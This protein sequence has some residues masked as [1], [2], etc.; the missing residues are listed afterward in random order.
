MKKNYY[1]IPNTNS[2]VFEKITI[3]KNNVSIKNFYFMFPYKFPILR[4]SKTF[5]LVLGI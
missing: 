4:F 1:Y 2:N 3:C 5:E